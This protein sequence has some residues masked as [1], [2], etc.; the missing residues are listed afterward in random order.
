MARAPMPSKDPD[1]DH[2]NRQ[3]TA[4]GDAE[5]AETP[6]ELLRA[7]NNG[8]NYLM[9]YVDFNSL[10]NNPEKEWEIILSEGLRAPPEPSLFD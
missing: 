3:S 2:T 9:Y 1:L 4:D 6:V 10:F 5:G 7:G 8:Q